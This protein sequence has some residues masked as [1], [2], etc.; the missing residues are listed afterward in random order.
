MSKG[1]RLFDEQANSALFPPILR[2]GYANFPK[3]NISAL[4]IYKYEIRKE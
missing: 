1:S 3:F 2:S 4:Q